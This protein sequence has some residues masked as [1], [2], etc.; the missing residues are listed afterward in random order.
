[1]TRP[2]Y[3]EYHYSILAHGYWS[4]T[5]DQYPV[6]TT[7]AK[8]IEQGY[9]WADKV[10]PMRL[11]WGSYSWP[12]GVEIHYV[13]KDSGVLCH[14]CANAELDRTLD[15][16]DDQFCIVAADLNYEDQYLY[17]DHCNAHIA[18]AH[19]IE[20]EIDEAA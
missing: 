17:C 7:F 10:V 13:T 15:Q 4:Q 18:P 20:E 6:G 14:K 2:V 19:G 16:D 9:A 3:I 1:M 8:V 12:G 5:Y 11:R